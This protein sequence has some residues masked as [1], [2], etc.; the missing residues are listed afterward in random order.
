VTGLQE[1]LPEVA[2][3]D[4]RYNRDY[5]EGRTSFFYQF[6]GY[7]DVGLYFDRLARW[8]RP[9]VGA[10]P[11]LDL[12][13][14]YGFLLARFDD[15]RPLHGCDVSAWAVEKARAR[16]P[17]AEFH[18]TDA[19]AALPYP[20]GT[21]EAVLC[22]DVLEHLPHQAQGPLVAE[23]ARVL[24]PG[25]RF[26]LT[27]PNLTLMRRLLY[28]RA[29]RA[30]THV[31]MRRIRAWEALLAES[32]LAIVDRWTYLHGFLPGRIR[33]WADWLPECAVVGRKEG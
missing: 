19:S 1:N 5:F 16:L 24:A 32:G 29:D 2:V 11:L 28:S 21:F 33:R 18:V 10:G 12:G 31:G 26:G 8:F 13:C 27:T 20:D 23:V 14:A 30:E 6:G 9:H 3:H 17:R 4:A 15:G 22:T 25:G 7:R